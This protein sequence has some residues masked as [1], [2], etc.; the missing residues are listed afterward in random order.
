MAM[1]GYPG[2]MAWGGGDAR[3]GAGAGAGAGGIGPP[4][5][6]TS[7]PNLARLG[8]DGTMPVAGGSPYANY[9]G[10][11]PASPPS[12]SSTATRAQE[13]TPRIGGS[14]RANHDYYDHVPM[15]AYADAKK[16]R[17]TSGGGR[18]GLISARLNR[19]HK[20]GQVGPSG[21][22]WVEGD[23]F[24]DACICTTNCRCRKSQRV[25]YRARVD[26][27]RASSGSD[28]EEH[29]Y[30]SGEIRYILK[31]DVGRDCGDHS[32]CRKGESQDSDK[33]EKRSR[34]KESKE[35]EKLQE[36]F[37]GLKDDLLEALD[38]RLED[39]RK[40][41]RHLS[42]APDPARPSVGASGL[43]QSSLMMNGRQV[44]PRMARQMPMVVNCNPY[45]MPT[46]G[47]GQ[48]PHGI[49]GLA[50]A[51]RAGFGDDVS[52]WEAD[53]G[54][55]EGVETPYLQPGWTV[56]RKQDRKKRMMMN[57]TGMP[58]P[59]MM[60]PDGAKARGRGQGVGVGVGEGM[61][62]GMGM[63]GRNRAMGRWS[64]GVV[65]GR[66]AVMGRH[67][68]RGNRRGG[69]ESESD[70]LD[71]VEPGASINSGK[72][73]RAGLDSAGKYVDDDSSGPKV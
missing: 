71:A 23:A 46:S 63:D 35:G 52:A 45:G 37:Q 15:G 2:N 65:D 24:L 72:G 54:H 6:Y 16:P 31:D 20:S 3:M 34:R 27:H 61:G 58:R 26:G 57:G 56:K 60:P 22:E 7:N 39:M 64:Q 73:Q 17:K 40:E 10:P 13:P 67:G 47:I 44:D 25:L 43:G 4:P 30:R 53:M 9:A 42:E 41:R 32:G 5:E 55:A 14:G 12:S 8:G 38:E 11:S 28:G 66:G 48:M 1:G 50:A 70:D 62:M 36:Q 49:S 21:K 29:E 19:G 69:L 33:E 68:S 59:N 51:G 18:D